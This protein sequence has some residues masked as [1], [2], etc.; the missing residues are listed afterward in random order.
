RP[1]LIRGQA[2]GTTLFA[3]DVCAALAAAFNAAGLLAAHAAARLTAFAAALA[4]FAGAGARVRHGAFDVLIRS[5]LFR[6]SPVLLNSMI[7]TAHL[8]RPESLRARQP[9]RRRRRATILQESNWCS[10][11]S[12]AAGRRSDSRPNARRY[13]SFA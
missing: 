13:E 2:A 4:G 7:R 9:T 6:H 12:A 1:I 5:S 8:S 11:C 3:A 10:D